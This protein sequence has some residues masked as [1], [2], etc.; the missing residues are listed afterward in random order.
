MGAWRH[1]LEA[2]FLFA[3]TGKVASVQPINGPAGR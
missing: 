1:N 2:P 3:V